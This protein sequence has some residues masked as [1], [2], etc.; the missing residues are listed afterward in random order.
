MIADNAEKEG[1][2]RNNIIDY[3]K[4]QK[5]LRHVEV[6]LAEAMKEGGGELFQSNIVLHGPPGAGKSSVK[7]II[8]GQPPLPKYKQNATDI[9][10]KSVRAVC[11]DRVTASNT[12]SG[13]F[14]VVDNEQI[15]ERIAGE[16]KALR[17]GKFDKPISSVPSQSSFVDTPVL[18]AEIPTISV[19]SLNPATSESEVPSKDTPLVLTSAEESI[20]KKLMDDKTTSKMFNSHWHH[21]VDSGGQ[22]QFLDVLPLLYRSPSHFIVVMRMTEGLDDRPKVRFSTKEMMSMSYQIIWYYPIEK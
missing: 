7:R 4:H 3:L 20:K 9:L 18:V 21:Y 1:Y 2:G 22:P 10:E 19:S 13:L 16:V 14:E 6:A 15:I 11:I 5:H 12:A 8:I 17:E